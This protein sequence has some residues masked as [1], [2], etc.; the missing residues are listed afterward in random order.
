M[1]GTF[2][3]GLM[4]VAC[5]DRV[6]SGIEHGCGLYRP[7]RFAFTSI[8]VKGRGSAV[9]RLRDDGEFIIEPN[10]PFASMEGS[11]LFP[12][13][14]N[15]SLNAVLQNC[16]VVSNVCVQGEQ[17]AVQTQDEVDKLK[18]LVLYADDPMSPFNKLRPHVRPVAMV[19]ANATQPYHFVPLIFAARDYE[20]SSP[21]KQRLIRRNATLLAKPE[22]SSF[23]D[24]PAVIYYGTMPYTFGEVFARV[25]VR[26]FELIVDARNASV[27]VIPALGSPEMLSTLLQPMTRH[28][29]QPLSHP[30]QSWKQASRVHEA[31]GSRNF[32]G[33][34][35][36]YYEAARYS[37]ETEFNSSVYR[38]F[39]APAPR[40]FRTA[41]VCKFRDAPTGPSRPWSTMQFLLSRAG[42]LRSQSR[43]AQLV[44]SEG[45]EGRASPLWPAEHTTTEAGPRLRVLFTN[46]TNRRQILNLQVLVSSCNQWV[47][48]NGIRACC[49]AHSLWN[50][51]L[52]NAE[53]LTQADVFISMHGS[54]LPNGF[55]LPSGGS[56]VEV[57]P[58]TRR[59]CPCSLY[60]N[61]YLSS[62]RE[63]CYYKLE[64]NN[65][66]HVPDVR[67]RSSYLSQ[68]VI[69]PWPALQ[70]VLERIV[71]VN[72]TLKNCNVRNY[73][74]FPF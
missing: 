67:Q 16:L 46:R 1:V 20:L 74:A 66:S 68:D 37:G 7:Y 41:T 36:E 26:L 69:L 60:T 31:L 47:A 43:V 45:S 42:K 8:L 9:V 44:H 32:S 61:L 4:H 58:V 19:M 71:R 2:G 53:V 64:S 11:L 59:D 70:N 5:M 51:T 34:L 29:I 14:N 24:E 22:E 55:A 18:N 33:I 38:M 50:G 65:L 21:L 48:Q 73:V 15:K 27:H 54:D 63:L 28:A 56:V 40:C 62:E 25:A 6:V 3:V 17:L 35:Q 57:M 23:S 72:G 13:S 30:I 12:G 10:T 52:K 39:D 49:I